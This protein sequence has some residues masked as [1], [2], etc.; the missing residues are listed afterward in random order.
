MDPLV[1][2]ALWQQFGATIDM[3]KNAMTACPDEQWH[4]LLWSV[5]EDDLSPDFAAFWYLSYHT[6]FWLDL[7]LTGTVEGFA[8]TSKCHSTAST[9]SSTFS[10]S[11]QTA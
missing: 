4:G 5:T 10:G 8:P 3:L 9:K 11:I 2:N 1:K 7:Y 6:L